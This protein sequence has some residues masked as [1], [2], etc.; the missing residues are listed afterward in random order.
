VKKTGAEKPAGRDNRLVTGI[1]ATLA[2]LTVPIGSLKPYG[3]NPRRGDVAAIRRSLEVNGQYR[4]VVARTGSG[5]VLAGNHTLA[6]ALEL[7][8][9]ELAATFVDVDDEQAARIVLVDNRT[10]DLAGY[11]QAVLAELLGDLPELDGSGYLAADLEALL[12]EL[13]DDQGDPGR[14]TEPG[15][16]PEEPVARPGD[17]WELGQHR[18]LCGDSTRPVLVDGLLDGAELELVWTDPP[19]GIDYRAAGSRRGKDRKGGPGFANDYE[20]PGRLERELLEPALRL[21]CERTRPG[22]AIYIAQGDPMHAGLHFTRAVLEAGWTVH[23]TLV[24]VKDHFVLSPQDYHWQHEAIL[25]GWRPGAAH[26]W[27]GDFREVTVLDDEELVGLSRPELVALVRRFQNDRGT[28]VIR[29]RRS[30]RNDLH[31]TVKP[32]GLIARQVGNSSMRGDAVYDPFAGSGSTLIAAENLGRRCFAVELDPRYVDVTV[33][34]WQ[35][36]TG[37]TA[38]RKGRRRR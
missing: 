32:V 3:R 22:G 15:P 6:A 26:R 38:R 19:Y 30:Y 24:W 34:R 23:Q 37:G 36:H 1:P 21:A 11:D 13:S 16:A 28:T 7:G 27:R 12:A 29:E 14:D 25:Y 9:A 31:P 8:W 2:E 18:V 35:R 17:V 5:E 33:D 10:A 4:P 20:N